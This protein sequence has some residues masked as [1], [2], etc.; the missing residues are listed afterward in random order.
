MGSDRLSLDTERLVLRRV[1]EDDF[2]SLADMHARAEVVR[3]LPWDARDGAT[4]RAAFERHRD[5]RFE[6]EGD[7]LCLAGIERSTGA[8]VG[9]FSLRWLTGQPPTGELG[10]ILRPD[11]AGRG[12]ATEGARAILRLGFEQLGFHRVVAHL[13]ARNT[14]SVRVLEKLGMRREAHFMRNRHI[15]EAWVDELVYAILAEEWHRG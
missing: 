13:D 2:A 11:A 5:A 6:E 9:E 4:A 7:S 10:Y 14:A 8:V 12:F 15:K 1:V 3:H